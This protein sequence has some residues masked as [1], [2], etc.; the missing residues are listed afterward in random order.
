MCNLYNV[1][2]NST[3][4]KQ[5][6]GHYIDE[7]NKAAFDEKI[8]PDY[9]AP[10]LRNNIDGPELSL[11][12]WGMPTPPIY[13][14]GEADKGI[15]NVRNVSSR[16][17]QQWLG[18]GSRCLVPATSFSEYSQEVDPETGKKPLHWFALNDKEPLFFFAGIWT[19]WI[20]VRKTS[21]GK[22]N[23]TLFAFLTSDPN[24]V[25]APIH[26]KAMPVILTEK[27]EL[28]MWMNAPW[29]VAKELQR[30]LSSEKLVLLK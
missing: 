9:Q 3:Q 20:G 1:K 28:D 7:T 27:S 13:V 18:V 11:S 14:K 24:S 16:H 2:V 25:V 19:E 22:Q 29:D 15:T 17:W 30:P 21:E 26:P 6:V 8:Y 23:H 4:L 12:R 10:I 5:A